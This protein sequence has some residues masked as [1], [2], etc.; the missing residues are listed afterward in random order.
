MHCSDQD[1]LEKAQFCLDYAARNPD[2]NGH[3]AQ[4]NRNTRLIAASLP[5]M[6]PYPTIVA[7]LSIP[8]EYRNVMENLHGGATATI[9]DVLTTL[10]LCLVP[11]WGFGGVSRSLSVTYLRPV[12][13]GEEIEV[14]GEVMGY[15][16][17]LA[18][19]R[20]TMTRVRDGKVVATC[21]H[22]K[23]NIEMREKL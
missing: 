18:L 13:G 5:P 22:E 14:K 23:V 21:E 9:F 20:G 17:Q 11:S 19:V 12:K 1:L 2:Y 8:P 6:T 3:D 4:L 15:G 10:P 16:K 7:H